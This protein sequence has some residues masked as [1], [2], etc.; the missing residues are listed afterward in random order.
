V[1]YSDIPPISRNEARAAF[2]TGDESAII[3]ALLSLTF[4]DPD[5]RWVQ[6]QLLQF[7]KHRNSSIRSLAG[8]CFGHLA[9]I[10]RALDLEVVLPV[11]R[12]LASDP[13]TRGQAED[14]LSDIEI[15]VRIG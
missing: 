6:D 13:E 8:L 15:F 9:R 5:W 3:A 7:A 1:R 2:R 14:A 4:H 11:H 10:H 12:E